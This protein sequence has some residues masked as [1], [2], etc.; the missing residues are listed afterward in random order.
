MDNATLFNCYTNWNAPDWSRFKSLET[1]GCITNV[2]ANG[3]THIDGNIPDHSAEFW[4]VYARDHDGMAEAI[5]DCKTRADVDAVAAHLSALSGLPV[6]AN[7]P[8]R[9]DTRNNRNELRVGGL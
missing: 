1:G 2:Q 4:K 3:S 6:T 8:A 7:H 5:T 9:K